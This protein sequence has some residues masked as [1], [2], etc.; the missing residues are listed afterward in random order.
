MISG[1]D[2]SRQRAVLSRTLEE[3]GVPVGTEQHRVMLERGLTNARA[4][5]AAGLTR[6]D[7]VRLALRARITPSHARELIQAAARAI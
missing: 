4:A 7:Q 2:E 1:F 6:E 5:H 3:F